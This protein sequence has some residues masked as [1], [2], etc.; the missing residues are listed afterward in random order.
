MRTNSN[1]DRSNQDRNTRL[2]IV[3]VGAPAELRVTVTPGAT[4]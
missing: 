4:I 1:P 2:P 3:S